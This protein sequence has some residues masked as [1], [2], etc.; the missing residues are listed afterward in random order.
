[1]HQ[2]D[3]EMNVEQLHSELRQLKEQHKRLEEENEALNIRANGVQVLSKWDFAEA[4]FHNQ[5][6][7]NTRP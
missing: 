1:M 2:P 6:H 5:T 3:D 4:V 7:F